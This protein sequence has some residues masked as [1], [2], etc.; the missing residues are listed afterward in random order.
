VTA[1]VAVRR[2]VSVAIASCCP[3]PTRPSQR[4]GR[5]DRAPRRPATLDIH[6]ETRK[7]LELELGGVWS[8]RLPNDL[9]DLRQHA[10]L[11]CGDVQ[12]VVLASR[13]NHCGHNAVR[14]V[15]D[16]R[17]RPRLLAG[18]ED[19]QWISPPLP[20]RTSSMRRRGRAAP[21]PR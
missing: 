12:V 8:A 11:R 4:S 19:L 1:A 3:G 7:A 13:V 9:R 5:G 14:D 21:C 2:V 20:F 18:P 16:V 6:L 17:K 10:F 15:I